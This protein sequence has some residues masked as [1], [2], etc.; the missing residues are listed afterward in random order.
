M[1]HGLRLPLRDA[2]LERK[3]VE[4]MLGI[5][6]PPNAPAP[7]TWTTP[8]WVSLVVILALVAAVTVYGFF[9]FRRKGRTVAPPAERHDELPKAA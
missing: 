8:D 2:R 4:T 9:V 5:G 6:L 7:L 3:E 1:T